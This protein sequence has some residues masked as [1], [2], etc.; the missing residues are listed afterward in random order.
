M[1]CVSLNMRIISFC[2]HALSTRNAS[3]TTWLVQRSLIRCAS[4][5]SYVP[6]MDHALVNTFIN[7]AGAANR[8]AFLILLH[9][10]TVSKCLVHFLW[11]CHFFAQRNVYKTNRRSHATRNINMFIRN[12][13]QIGNEM[14]QLLLHALLNIHSCWKFFGQSHGITGSGGRGKWHICLR[15]SHRWPRRRGSLSTGSTVPNSHSKL[16]L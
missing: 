9:Q 12:F 8:V 5:S 10:T 1:L 7:V 4:T 14:M 11:Q 6:W 15:T 2:L 13:H 16:Q 3:V